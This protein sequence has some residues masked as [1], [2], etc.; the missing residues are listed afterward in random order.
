MK[1]P[2]NIICALSILG[3]SIAPAFGRGGGPP[4]LATASTDAPRS[5]TDRAVSTA[6]ARLVKVPTD[7]S[8]MKALAAAFLQKVRETADPTY[9]AK[10][11]RILATLGSATSSDPEVLLIEGTLLLARHEFGGALA[12]GKRAIAALPANPTAQA[13]V[14]DALNELGRYAD[15]LAATQQLVDRYPGLAA[16]SRVSFA[17]ELRGDVPGAIEAMQSA[18]TAGGGGGENV[19]YVQTLLGNL[20]L[21]NGDITQASRTYAA[22]LRS[23]PGFAAARAGQASVLLARGRPKEAARLFGEVVATEPLLQYVIAEGDSY[24][25]ANMTT[26][27]ADAYRLVDAIK[28]LNRAN[29]VDIDLEM[30]VFEADHRPSAALIASTRRAIRE[31]PS[32]TGHDAMA[33]VL[34][35][36]G[37]DREAA[38]EIE[39]V[40]ALGDR[41][42]VFRFHAAAI[43]ASVGDE[44]RATAQLD[45]V[46]T[47]NPR[48]LRIGSKELASLA[49][50]LGRRVPPPA[51]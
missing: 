30:A 42:P 6:Q 31:R 13:I 29:G 39:H 34:H 45:I 10:V 27:A 11:D 43:L 12:I 26:E 9:Y 35:R 36:A 19:A 7:R 22:A 20:L 40:L 14:V 24:A 2:R 25:A 38:I 18:V 37:K 46:L 5:A 32:V 47:S 50:K 8:A 28:K 23:F 41:D 3:L 1:T 44:A 51:P 16:F 4:A 49:S 21:A 33:W 15:A 48:A 17:R